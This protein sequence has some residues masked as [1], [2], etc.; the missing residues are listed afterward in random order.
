MIHVRVLKREQVEQEA[1]GILQRYVRECDGT[2]EPPI[3]VD[4]IGEALCRLRWD[5]DVIPDS[6]QKAGQIARGSDRSLVI[7]AGLYPRQRRVVLNEE[8]LD[9]F[10][11]KPGL[12]RFTKGHEIGHWVLHIDHGKLDHPSLFDLD[13]EP[14]PS[15]TIICR[16]GEDTWIE[17]QADWFSAALLMP[18]EQFLEI[19]CA[20][21]FR[22]WQARYELAERFGVTISAL[23]T[24][25]N[26]L[27]LSYVDE[28]GRFFRSAAEARGQLRL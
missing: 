8:H 11:E 18:K 2:L 13:E 4:L 26:R 9:L 22:N 27:G 28:Q 15:E 20:Y 1:V 24:R 7:L 12:E 14:D 16:D 6:R 17:R 25:L 21:D 5:W 10:Q 3:D 23:G 19:A